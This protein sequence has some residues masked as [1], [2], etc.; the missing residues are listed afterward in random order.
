MTNNYYDSDKHGYM[1]YSDDRFAD[2]IY[3]LIAD[4]SFLNYDAA[5]EFGAGM[6]R[7][8]ASIIKHFSKTTLVEP[9]PA[10]TDI[11]KK[12]FPNNCVRILN[13]S[14]E[15]FLS[16]QTSYEP[17]LV[18]C[19]HLM[20]H[21]TYEQ[22][23]IIYHYIKKTGSKC[24]L[25]EPNPLNPLILLQIIFHPDMSLSEEIQYLSLTYNRYKKEIESSGLTLTS[26]KR[27]CF[28]PPAITNIIYKKTSKHFIASFEALN[29]ILPF[30][31][32][33]Q[34]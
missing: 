5:I 30:M 22:R 12:K 29:T 26:L 11:L 17:A 10:Y 16:T 3:S 4:D 9:V 6:G 2:Y 13:C 18:F 20:H 33:Y 31:S 27:F 19:F 14:V 21:L 23:K 28:F 34:L 1:Q 25:V 32:S 7:F 24:V 8:S 15:K